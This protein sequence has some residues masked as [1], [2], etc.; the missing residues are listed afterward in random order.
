MRVATQM[1]AGSVALAALSIVTRE[2][3]GFVPADISVRS[4]LALVYLITFGAIVGYGAYIWLLDHV[5][6]ARAGTYAYVNPVVA[7]LLGWAL[8]DEPVTFRSLLAAAIILGSVV[9]ITTE[10][11][12]RRRRAGKPLPATTT[13]VP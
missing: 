5:E 11:R 6:P 12:V 10:V 9:V 13:R 4:W 2:A 7:M 1:L 3:D 8:A